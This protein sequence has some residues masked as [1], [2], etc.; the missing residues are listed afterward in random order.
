MFL[1]FAQKHHIDDDGV[2]R[3]QITTSHATVNLTNDYNRNAEMNSHKVTMYTVMYSTGDR[4]QKGRLVTVFDPNGPPHPDLK[5][6]RGCINPD[7]VAKNRAVACG[8]I[9]RR[10]SGIASHAR[11]QACNFA[12]DF[13]P[14]LC[15]ICGVS[16]ESNFFMHAASMIFHNLCFFCTSVLNSVC[17]FT[18]ISVKKRI[19]ALTKKFELAQ[20]ELVR[21]WRWQQIWL[22]ENSST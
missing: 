13:D 10:N 8:V 19:T 5:L 16:R 3:R 7:G 12:V 1:I 22:S 21:R 20:M 14:G 4:R 15:Y 6:E 9:R 2:Q 18:Q 11:T 17:L